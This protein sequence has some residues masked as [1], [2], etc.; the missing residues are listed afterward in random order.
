MG[1]GQGACGEELLAGEQ[2]QG[3]GLEGKRENQVKTYLHGERCTL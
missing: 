1:A 3:A 2:A